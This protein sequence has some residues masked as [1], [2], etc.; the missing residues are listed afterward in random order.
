MI[1]HQRWDQVGYHSI[2]NR[3]LNIYHGHIE[4]DRYCLNRVGTY[5]NEQLIYLPCKAFSLRCYPNHLFAFTA[6][7][8]ITVIAIIISTTIIIIGIVVVIILWTID[9]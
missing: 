6:A 7:I 3:Y 8:I 4:G 9:V 1:P 5:A 2:Y